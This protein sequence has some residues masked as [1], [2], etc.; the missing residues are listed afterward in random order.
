L[1]ASGIRANRQEHRIAATLRYGMPRNVTPDQL[2]LAAAL[3]NFSRLF[4]TLR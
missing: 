4:K 1:R 3:R 2:F